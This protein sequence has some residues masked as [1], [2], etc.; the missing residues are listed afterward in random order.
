MNDVIGVSLFLAAGIKILLSYYLIRSDRVKYGRWLSFP[1]TSGFRLAG[2]FMANC[3]FFGVFGLL[4][5]LSTSPIPWWYIAL[6]CNI[7]LWSVLLWLDWVKWPDGE[8]P[9]S[10]VEGGKERHA[11]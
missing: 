7:L 10:P 9:N 4:T 3:F 1:L 5:L 6:V 2:C 11:H 8:E